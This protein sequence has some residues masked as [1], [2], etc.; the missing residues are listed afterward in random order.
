MANAHPAETQAHALIERLESRNV[1]QSECERFGLLGQHLVEWSKAKHSDAEA[2]ARSYLKKLY[3]EVMGVVV[4][5]EP[6]D[7]PGW[8]KQAAARFVEDLPDG[9]LVDALRSLS[10]V[11][12]AMD[13][14]RGKWTREG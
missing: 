11:R 9:E 6:R 8:A 4:P 12:R 5:R 3:F 13:Q 1:I 7:D 14:A 10:R 2:A